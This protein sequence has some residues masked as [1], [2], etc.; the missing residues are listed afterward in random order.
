MGKQN[1]PKS[2]QDIGWLTSTGETREILE[3]PPTPTTNHLNSS[4]KNGSNIF[5]NAP[6][7]HQDLGVGLGAPLRSLRNTV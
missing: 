1:I 6:Y 4:E 3:R 7:L 5:K 2:V